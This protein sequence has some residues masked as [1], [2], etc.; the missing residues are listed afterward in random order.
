MTNDADKWC[1]DVVRRLD[2]HAARLD[3]LGGADAELGAQLESVR[4]ELSENTSTTRRIDENTRGLLEVMQSW[5]GAMQV[6]Q[7]VGR[8]FK[9][10]SYIAVFVSAVA[11]AYAALKS[12]ITPK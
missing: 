12:G 8:F 10:L 1:A 9:P 6:I 2:E 5:S 11:G 7:S 4:A 3:K